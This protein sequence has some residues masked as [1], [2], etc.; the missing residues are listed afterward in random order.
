MHLLD[1]TLEASK[2]ILRWRAAVQKK[3]TLR[4][5]I[6]QYAIV[7]GVKESK[8]QLDLMHAELQD[9]ADLVTDLNVVILQQI[10]HF[11]SQHAAKFKETIHV[12]AQAKQKSASIEQ[13]A[14]A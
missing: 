8:E 4:Q 6:Q 1:Q 13:Q 11:Q 9:L 12:A 7:V 10:E 14:W 3:F 5:Q 2:V